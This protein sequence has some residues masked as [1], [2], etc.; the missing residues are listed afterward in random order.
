MSSP[1]LRRF[2]P[3]RLEMKANRPK[4]V[5]QGFRFEIR[6]PD[7]VTGVSQTDFRTGV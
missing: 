5:Y 6:Y 2:H 3:K 1:V 4:S 7:R